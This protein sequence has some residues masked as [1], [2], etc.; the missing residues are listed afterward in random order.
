M[1][2]GGAGETDDAGGRL[3]FRV[4]L[5]PRFRSAARSLAPP[6]SPPPP[7]S[8]PLLAARPALPWRGDGGRAR[9]D[10]PAR[11]IS[12]EKRA[13]RAP[14]AA[15]AARPRPLLIHSCRSFRLAHRPLLS[16]PPPS[17][18][19]GNLPEADLLKTAADVEDAA[20]KLQKDAG[21]ALVGLDGTL[22][23]QVRRERM[24]EK[25]ER[26]SGAVGGGDG[27]RC[28]FYQ[29]PTTPP[30]SP[31]LP[32]P[33]LPGPRLDLL[34]GPRP[35][36]LRLAVGAGQVLCHGARRRGRARARHVQVLRHQLPLHGARAGRRH[37]GGGQ[38]RLHQLHRPRQARPGRHRQGGRRP[39]H[40]RAQH[41]GRPGQAGRRV[42]AGQ[43]GRRR[44]A[45]PA[46]RGR[47]QGAQG[48]GRA[49]GADARADPHAPGRQRAARRL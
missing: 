21:I 23:D 14:L 45:R 10:A 6:P 1:R 2:G 8:R 19:K 35:R 29:S 37:P 30:S 11:G 25:R 31:P 26:E 4:R 40:H 32:P 3:I 36:P 49:R 44:R 5:P 12:I 9:A 18:W 46:L 47:A 22:Y 42:D 16:S 28:V 13:P 48:A 20:W 34:P 7:A 38:A 39:D 15:R 33:F 43:V 41:A 27:G 24:G 17:F